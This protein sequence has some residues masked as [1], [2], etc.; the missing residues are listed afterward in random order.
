[1]EPTTMTQPQ[2]SQTVLSARARVCSTSVSPLGWEEAPP[3]CEY[4]EVGGSLSSIYK[5]NREERTWAPWPIKLTK[6]VRVWRRGVL[7]RQKLLREES[8]AASATPN[9]VGGPTTSPTGLVMWA[10]GKP[11]GAVGPAAALGPGREPCECFLCTDAALGAERA[12]SGLF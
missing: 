12:S 2:K 4:Q 9:R 5:G 8:F 10:S 6:R 1:M 7:E 11:F 3:W